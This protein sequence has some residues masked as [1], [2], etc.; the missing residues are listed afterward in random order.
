MSGKVLHHDQQIVQEGQLMLYA[1]RLELKRTGIYF[2]TYYYHG[3]AYTV[4]L[5]RS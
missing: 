2:L 5:F 4:E 1:Q 3:K